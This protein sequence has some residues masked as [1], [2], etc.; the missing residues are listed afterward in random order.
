MF[1]QS[2]VVWVNTRSHI[3]HFKVERYLGSTMEG[4]F[5]CECDAAKEG[6]RPARY[7]Q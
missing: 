2:Q 5:A 1:G 4:K 7:G 3:Y 6:D